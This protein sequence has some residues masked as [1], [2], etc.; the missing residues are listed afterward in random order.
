MVGE[1]TII[2]INLQH[3]T[4]QESGHLANLSQ[5]ECSLD[6]FLP[7][8]SCMAALDEAWALSAEPTGARPTASAISTERTMRYMAARLWPPKGNQVN[9]RRCNNDEFM[10]SSTSGSVLARTC[11]P[12]SWCCHDHPAANAPASGKKQHVRCAHWPFFSGTFYFAVAEVFDAPKSTAFPQPRF[13]RRRREL[14]HA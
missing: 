4:P 1:E 6:V 10:F 12:L 7:W 14:H 2:P 5:H 13:I 3:L 11:A 9:S 8:Q